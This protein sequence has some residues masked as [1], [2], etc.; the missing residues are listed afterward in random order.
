MAVSAELC[1]Q[2][3]MKRQLR[4]AATCQ[5]EAERTASL[6]KQQEARERRLEVRKEQQMKQRELQSEFLNESGWRLLG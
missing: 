3:M 2:D 4:E 6:A 5:R 1:R